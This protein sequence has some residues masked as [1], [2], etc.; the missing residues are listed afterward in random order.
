VSQY[1]ISSQVSFYVVT[2]LNWET[3]ATTTIFEDKSTLLLLPSKRSH[4]SDKKS[5]MKW[6]NNMNSNTVGKWRCLLV[7]KHSFHQVV[8]FWE[9]F[10]AFRDCY[11]LI[12]EEPKRANIYINLT[13][14]YT[15]LGTM[16]PWWSL[17]PFHE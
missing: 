16:G 6:V 5:E 7:C 17:F 8:S 10:L 9:K 13:R 3:K 14:L 12:L 2:S 15:H 4:T 11:I 1:T